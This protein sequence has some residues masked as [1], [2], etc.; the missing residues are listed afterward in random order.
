MD[1]SSS[2]GDDG[3]MDKDN[4]DE[5]APDVLDQPDAVQNNVEALS[6]KDMRL[7]NWNVELLNRSLRT[8]IL[9][10]KVAKIKPSPEAKMKQLE[11]MV[12]NKSHYVLDEVQDVIEMPPFNLDVA[13]DQTSIDTVKLDP[14][15]NEQLQHYLQ[16][17]AALYK[18]N[19]FHNFEHASHVT[20]SVVKLF[21]R[22]VQPADGPEHSG[23]TKTEAL[24]A[25]HN[26]TFG[27]T[28]DP[29]VCLT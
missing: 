28:S 21:S 25:L 13:R 19:P 27:L 8:I 16:T 22:I 3:D 2:Y 4:D 24:R 7:I 29:L 20:M 11:D 12:L 23:E 6:D 26:K 15:V 1:N 18:D 14:A 9:G 17:I 5:F 10:R